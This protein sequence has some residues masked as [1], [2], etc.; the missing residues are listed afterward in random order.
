MYPTWFFCLDSVFAKS[1]NLEKVF[2]DCN[3]NENDNNDD[4]GGVE[5]L[6]LHPFWE[7]EDEDYIADDPEY[8]ENKIRLPPHSR[9]AAHTL[10][11]VM[12]SDANKYVDYAPQQPN[13]DLETP[14]KPGKFSTLSYETFKKC[15]A[16]WTSQNKATNSADT[17]HQKLG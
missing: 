14:Q 15:K 1:Y 2:V 10:N 16:L 6:E 4:D 13:E 8:N 12:S 5:F 17:V 7:Q 11:L 3:N 9:C